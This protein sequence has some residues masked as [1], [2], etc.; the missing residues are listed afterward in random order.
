MSPSDH[1]LNWKLKILRM[2]RPEAEPHRLEFLGFSIRYGITAS[3]FMNFRVPVLLSS[4]ASYC[5]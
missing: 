4:E 2:V 5:V 3:T 1:A